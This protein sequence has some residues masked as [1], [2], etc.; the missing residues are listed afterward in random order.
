VLF[1]S[2]RRFEYV[3]VFIVISPPFPFILAPKAPINNGAY[4]CENNKKCK[5]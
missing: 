4:N 5:S 1:R 2:L 3:W